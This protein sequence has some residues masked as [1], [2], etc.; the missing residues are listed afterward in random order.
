MSMV[1][2]DIAAL[3]EFASSLRYRRQ[4]IDSTRQHLSAVVENLPWAGDD[5]DRFVDEW[6]RVHAPG[7]ARIVGELASAAREASD[8]ADRQEQ[9]S[10]RWV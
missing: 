2:A 6:R 8:H 7:I 5:R 3:R 9:A 4:E 10:R 1:G